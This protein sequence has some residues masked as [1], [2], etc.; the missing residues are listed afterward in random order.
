M[1]Q[2]IFPKITRFNHK[3]ERLRGGF[4]TFGNTYMCYEMKTSWHFMIIKK[5]MWCQHQSCY[6]LQKSCYELDR[7]V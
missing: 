2:N 1:P 6:E 4:K 3:R 5:Y 7:M